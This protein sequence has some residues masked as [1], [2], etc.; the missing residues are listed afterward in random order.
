RGHTQ[1]IRPERHETFDEGTIA[2]DSY[3]E[4]RSRFARC[5][6]NQAATSLAALLIVSLSRHAEGADSVSD[7]RGRG[8]LGRAN[9]GRAAIELC[10]Q[11]TPGIRNSLTLSLAGTQA[12]SIERTKRDIH[13]A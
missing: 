8:A 6:F 10:L 13:E 3:I 2:G 7:R 9:S 1:M 5:D 12:E 4:R 11:P